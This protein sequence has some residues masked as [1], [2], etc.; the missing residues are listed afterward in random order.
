MDPE[1]YIN[2]VRYVP[3]SSI[4][5]P[6]IDTL[7]DALL[8][9]W[10]VQNADGSVRTYGD[11]IEKATASVRVIVTDDTDYNPN[12]PTVADFITNLRVRLARKAT[13]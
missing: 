2:G 4:E 7:R 12:A 13:P 10:Y 6:E 8:G 3:A 1:V 5:A 9:L 11:P